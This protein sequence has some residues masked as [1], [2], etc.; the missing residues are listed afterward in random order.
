[1]K[2]LF[3]NYEFPPL[4]GGGGR[5][6]AQIARKMAE[7]GHRVTIITSAFQNL[8]EKENTQ[9][10]E[11]IRIPTKRRYQEKC[12]I[13]EMT[14]FMLSA[15]FY[16]FWWAKKNRPDRVIAFFTLPSAPAAYVLKKV[17]GIPYLVSLRGG[18][19]PGFMPE[20]LS[21][22]H[23]VA[24]PFIRTIWK[25]AQTVVANSQGLK[26]LAQKTDQHLPIAIVPNGVDTFF[27][28]PTPL[29]SLET[30]KEMPTKQIKEFRILSVGR[31]SS[32]KRVDLLLTAYAKIKP[33]M[34]HLAQ[35]WI[36]GDG[37][38][39]DELEDLAQKL[40]IAKEVCFLGW[41]EP[42]TLKKFYETALAF[43]ALRTAYVG[44]LIPAI[45]EA[46]QR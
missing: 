16:S 7:M 17:L 41:L 23:Q 42:E 30:K 10:F 13:F 28:N 25:N 3:I 20:Q 43:H 24:R 9:G 22:Y 6:S 39:R 36:V 15:I 44:Q 32:Q 5:A 8:P 14:V 26:D 34:K 12:S 46:H 18:D 29:I 37:P 31:L 33:L 35:L 38:L 19:V 45:Q 1:M 2:L 40:G 27:F 21:V 4:G 11:V